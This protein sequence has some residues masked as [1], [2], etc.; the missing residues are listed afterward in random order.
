ML[1][2]IIGIASVV[3]VVAL[4]QG[5]QQQVLRNISS[6][7]TNTLEIYP[8]R[9]FGDMRSGRITTL[10][11]DDADAL[12]RQP[13]VAAVTPSVSTS[14]TARH[15]SRRGQRPDQR[16]RRGLFPTPPAPRSPRAGPSTRRRCAADA[17]QE[18]VIDENTRTSLFPNAT[19]DPIGQVILA[20]NVLLRIVG[21]A[22]VPQRGPGS[23]GTCRFTCPIR[24][25]RRGFWPRPASA[26]S[27]SG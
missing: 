2:I 4:G 11:V 9:D 19:D 15:G 14:A 13:F 3:P 16:R 20:N 17:A 22:S 25:C 23:G 18:V 24:R 26:A 8:G 21:V 27:R 10:V 6:L 5:S 12:G 1:G 7:G